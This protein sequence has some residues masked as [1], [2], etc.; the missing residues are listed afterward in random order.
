VSPHHGDVLNRAID[1]RV[2][3]AEICRSLHM[4]SFFPPWRE[5]LLVL[6]HLSDREAELVKQS[7]DCIAESKDLI[8]RAEILV[9]DH[10]P[11]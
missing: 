11:A 7:R 1:R 4:T 2:E 8:A 9:R 3:F 10:W 5:R 6:A